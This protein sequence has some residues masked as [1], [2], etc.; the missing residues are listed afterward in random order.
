[1]NS[2]RA[3]F[4][5]RIALSAATAILILAGATL[6]VS[7]RVG[8][9][10]LV[11][12]SAGLLALLAGALNRM[13]KA[14][15][16]LGVAAVVVSVLTP[17][18]RPFDLVGLLLLGLGGFAG[19]LAYRSFTDAMR[20]QLDDMKRLNMQ[21]EEKHRAFLA[22]TSDADSAVQPG[23]VAALTA[24]MSRLCEEP[25]TRRAMGGAIAVAL[26]QSRPGHGSRTSARHP[27]SRASSC[28]SQPRPP[29]SSPSP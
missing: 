6:N 19:S 29:C 18:F 12:A 25:K 9:G 17:P 10:S 24:A 1:M 4:A 8:Q 5:L 2:D 15:V 11:A 27:R 28:G 7:G 3:T 14:A 23:D 13:W 16:P 20:R 22:A 21:L 26:L